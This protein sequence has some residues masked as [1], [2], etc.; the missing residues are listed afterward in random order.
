MDNFEKLERIGQ[1]KAVAIIKDLFKHCELNIDQHIIDKNEIDIYVTATTKNGK[2]GRYSIEA[3]DR[4]TDHNAYGGKWMIEKKK[5]YNLIDDYAKGY[6]TLYLNT[7][8]DNTYF[9]WNPFVNKFNEGII[10]SEKYTAYPSDKVDKPSYFFNINDF[11]QSGT[12][13]N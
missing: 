4:H 2:V 7:F 5:M 13:R 10:R 1:G 3:K 9:I 8:A 6:T 12:T 11:V